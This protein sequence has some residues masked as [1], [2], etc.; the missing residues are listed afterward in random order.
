MRALVGAIIAAGSLIGLG[1]ASIGIGNR[2][3]AVILRDSDGKIVGVALHEMDKALLAIL[4]LLTLT[5]IIGMVVA[6]I[7]LAY[8][9][10]RR[11]LEL[12]RGSHS[13]AVANST[14]P[15]RILS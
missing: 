5:A 12:M 6:F 3:A 10:H 7:G 14:T 9:H 11:H 1:L 4:V 2:Y 13:P 15:A 8:H